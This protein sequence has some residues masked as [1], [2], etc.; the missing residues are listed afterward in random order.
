VRD[1]EESKRQM[2]KAKKGKGVDSTNNERVPEMG[3]EEI[4]AQKSR[5]V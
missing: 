4:T 2:E 1:E 3:V 5:L